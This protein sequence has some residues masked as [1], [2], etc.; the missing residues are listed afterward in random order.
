MVS[1][2]DVN[3]VRDVDPL[4][5]GRCYIDHSPCHGLG[6]NAGRAL[7][8]WRA[9]RSVSCSCCWCRSCHQLEYPGHISV[10]LVQQEEC[11]VERGSRPLSVEYYFHSGAASSRTAAP[12]RRQ[13]CGAALGPTSSVGITAARPPGRPRVQWL[14]RAVTRQLASSRVSRPRIWIQIRPPGS[15]HAVCEAGAAA[16]AQTQAPE[17][18]EP[19]T[20]PPEQQLFT[21]LSLRSG[22]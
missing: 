4:T 3:S 19:P 2:P 5:A 18:A 6:R 10:K 15:T 16:G 7:P 17:K 20:A 9:L 1:G 8:A 22:R 11:A 21:R 14:K 13:K 12:N